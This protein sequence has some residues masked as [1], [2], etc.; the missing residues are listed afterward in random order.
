ELPEVVRI[1]CEKPADIFGLSSKG[2]IAK[3][4][5]A[6][7]IVVDLEKEKKVESKKLFTKCKWSPYDGYKFKGWSVMTFVGGELVFKNGKP[8][9]DKFGKE[10][11]FGN[12]CGRIAQE[13]K[14]LS[15]I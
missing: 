8:L 10:V 12:F 3:W 14:V 5:D 9:G 7:V 2:K 1:L 15:G 11:E 13:C 4:Y 6:D